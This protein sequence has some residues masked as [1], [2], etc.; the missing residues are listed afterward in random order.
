MTNIEVRHWAPTRGAF[1]PSEATTAAKTKRR[2]RQD[3]AQ[4]IQPQVDGTATARPPSLCKTAVA[5]V[6]S[7]Y[8][9]PTVTG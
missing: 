6:R 1:Q 9:R 5:L 4:T 3:R 8:R 2:R 7:T